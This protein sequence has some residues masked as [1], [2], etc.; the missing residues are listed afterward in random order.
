MAV[1]STP[2]GDRERGT[3]YEIELSANGDVAQAR[4]LARDVG[5]ELEWLRGRVSWWKSAG[6]DVTFTN[7]G[8][9]AMAI[10][11]G[12]GVLAGWVDH[13]DNSATQAAET[14]PITGL[15]FTATAAAQSVILYTGHDLIEGPLDAG[16]PA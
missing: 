15:R 12:N 16:T 6:V 14:L 2:G 9:D 13:P 1:T 8:P 3:W 10:S 5:A 4:L 7:A 11:G